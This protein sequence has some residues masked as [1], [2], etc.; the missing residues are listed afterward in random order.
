VN[1]VGLHARPVSL[2][3]KLVKDVDCEIGVFKNG[4][5]AQKEAVRAIEDFIWNGCGE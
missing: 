4:I 2:L 3:T 1:D 5:R